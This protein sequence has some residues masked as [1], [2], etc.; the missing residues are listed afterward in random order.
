MSQSPFRWGI[1]GPGRIAHAFARAIAVVDAAVI[2]AV[3]SRDLAR[4][5]QFAQ[6]FEVSTTYDSYAA[7]IADP[8]IDA[9]YI[10][11]PHRFH[12]EQAL[13]CL[14]AGKAVLC[15]KPLT[16][17]AREARRLIEAAQ[18]NRAFLLEAVWTRYLPIFQHVRHWLDA[19][20]IGE[21]RLLTSTFGFTS[22]RDPQD[23]LLNHDLA[24]GALLDLGIYNLTLSQW[25]MGAEPVDFAAHAILG[26]TVV[27]ELT[28][29]NLQYASGAVS[30]WTCTILAD[31][32]NSLQIYGSAGR[33]QV[34]TPFWGATQATLVTAEQEITVSEPFRASGFE[35]QI[36]DAMRCIR[37]GLIESPTMPH[38]QTLATMTL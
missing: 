30:Q 19:G 24:G 34:H 33:I 13:S 15:E 37:A 18:A 4:A 22:P 38:A 35:Y 26:P 17:N 28:S 21:I 2:H 12:F 36:E 8:A 20:S 3:A 11:T 31:T 16:V 27:D 5:Q 25:V 9:I 23:R 14:E 29:V 1:I 6:A 32:S 7:L 10:A